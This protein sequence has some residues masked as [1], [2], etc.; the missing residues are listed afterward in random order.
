M[1]RTLPRPGLLLLPGPALASAARGTGRAHAG[2]PADRAEP[3]AR[4]RYTRSA[5]EPA[6][7]TGADGSEAAPPPVGGGGFGGTYTS[8]RSSAPNN[9]VPEG[10]SG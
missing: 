3:G 6:R 7:V 4:A 2:A 8:A 5:A 1:M 9:S 10:A